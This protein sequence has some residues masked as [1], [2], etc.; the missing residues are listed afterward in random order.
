MATLQ[1][2]TV[3]GTPELFAVPE[4]GKVLEPVETRLRRWRIGPLT[5]SSARS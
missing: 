2:F 5:L 3:H 4:E 1:E